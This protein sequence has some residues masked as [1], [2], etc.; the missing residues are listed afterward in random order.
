MPR[1]KRKSVGP[2]VTAEP[3][4]LGAMSNLFRGTPAEVAALFDRHGLECVQI[5]PQFAGIHFETAADVTAKACKEIARPFRDAAVVVAAVS[6]HTNFVD[7]DVSRRKRQVARFEALLEHC[8]D[9]GAR[10]IVTES[11]T[12]NASRPWDYHPENGLPESFA[13]LVRALKPMV[14][15]AESLG[16]TLLIEPHLYHV[17]SSLEACVQLREA[18]GPSL[19]FV[20]DPANVFTRSMA[21]ASKKPLRQFFAGIG[22]ACPIAHGKDV[23][24]HG[25]EWTTPRTGTGT[26]DYPEFLNLWGQHH[27]GAP[28]ILEQITAAELEETIDFLDRLFRKA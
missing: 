22:D 21:S 8:R 20:M 2:L 23:R 28:L 17:V 10:C 27:P 14:A 19:G 5:L 15:K 11:G 18:L 12:L 9:L 16:V 25:S 26:L 6:A 1:S 7:P 24:Y 13:Q 3:P 4:L